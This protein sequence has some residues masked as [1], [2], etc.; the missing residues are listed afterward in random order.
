MAAAGTVPV[1]VTAG[2]PPEGAADE[3]AGVVADGSGFGDAAACGCGRA[4]VGDADVA[5]DGGA[6]GAATGAACVAGTD[7]RGAALAGGRTGDAVLR[8]S[9]RAGSEK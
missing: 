9:T 5:P 6:E 8:G 4:A 3:A 7:V 2:L 1:D